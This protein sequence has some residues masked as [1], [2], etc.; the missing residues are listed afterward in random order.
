MS[1][2]FH[3]ELE[4]S[5]KLHPAVIVGSGS[6][7]AETT[8]FRADVGEGKALVIGRVEYF[9]AHLELLVLA[10]REFLGEREIHVLD[11]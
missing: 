6:D 4:A 5:A 8:V 11:A 1:S 2:W 7:G 10:D 9:S 3:L